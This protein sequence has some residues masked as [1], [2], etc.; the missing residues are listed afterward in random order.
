MECSITHTPLP[1]ISSLKVYW[2]E[3]TGKWADHFHARAWWKIRNYNAPA[4][5][6]LRVDRYTF[7]HT[8]VGRCPICLHKILDGA[9]GT[10]HPQSR[11][12]H[13]FL[14]ECQK[15]QIACPLSAYRSYAP[16]LPLP[17]P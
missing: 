9:E 16:I 15:T 3:L 4:L 12:W 7:S 2:D 17:P 1:F 5:V 6:V 11:A 10:A 13:R 8:Y 14:F